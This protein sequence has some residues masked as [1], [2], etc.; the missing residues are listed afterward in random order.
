MRPLFGFFN[1]QWA[2][3][4]S[5][6]SPIP[7]CT[8]LSNLLIKFY[9]NKNS[10]WKLKNLF[11]R[12]VYSFSRYK[13]RKL[14]CKNQWITYTLKPHISPLNIKSPPSTVNIPDAHLKCIDLLS[15]TKMWR[16][17][18]LQNSPSIISLN[19]CRIST[20]LWQGSLLCSILGCHWIISPTRYSKSTPIGP[21]SSHVVYKVLCSHSDNSY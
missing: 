7:L 20:N 11:L 8:N 17:Y 5:P 19:R 15:N 1:G 2:A 13:L 18:L 4:C 6:N 9:L 10:V 12:N 3:R 16:I 21:L 14:D